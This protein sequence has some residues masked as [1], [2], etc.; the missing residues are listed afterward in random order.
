MVKN[1]LIDSLDLEGGVLCLDFANTVSDRRLTPVQDYFTDIY[2]FLYWAANKAGIVTER[3]AML[4]EKTI[5][6]N[7]AKAIGFFKEAIDLRELIYAM[8]YRVS[9][10][11]DIT[12]G[13]LNEFN[14]ILKKYIPYTKLQK[15]G[16]GFEE[17]CALEEDDLYIL[18]VPI[19]KSAHELLLS[20]KLE[21][22]KQCGSDNCG[23]LFLDTSKNGKRHWCSM[24][25]CG[26]KDKAIK[27]YYRKKEAR[28]Q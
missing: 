19:I 28:E 23:W 12:A 5:K 2:A 13:Q 7:P 20:G 1:I 22:I 17:V 4:L 25:T 15:K 14:A 11:E 26:S 10:N 24:K 16:S 3:E 9:R 8:F 18:T 27:Y 6:E 21:K